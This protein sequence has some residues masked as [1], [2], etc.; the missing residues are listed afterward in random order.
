MF[1]SRGTPSRQA[2]FRKQAL[3]SWIHGRGPFDVID[4]DD[5]AQSFGRPTLLVVRDLLPQSIQRICR[6][7]WIPSFAARHVTQQERLVAASLP[8]KLDPGSPGLRRKSL[9]RPCALPNDGDVAVEEHISHWISATGLF[10]AVYA[11]PGP[12]NH[13]LGVAARPIDYLRIQMDGQVLRVAEGLQQ[14]D[15]A[16]FAL[17]FAAD[18]NPSASPARGRTEHQPNLGTAP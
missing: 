16:P 4:G 1:R 12:C 10:Q 7:R 8:D 2:D 11:G 18:K 17:P 15:V 14:A 13:P 9:E 3:Q 6:R 5:L